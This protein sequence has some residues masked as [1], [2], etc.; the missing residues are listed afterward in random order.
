MA[1]A[2]EAMAWVDAM[3]EAEPERVDTTSSTASVEKKAPG[4][5][6]KK[7]AKKGEV[8]SSLSRA[9]MPTPLQTPDRLFDR[10][11]RKVSGRRLRGCL[12]VI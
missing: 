11:L 5:R 8:A 6:K 7:A 4:A 12:S 9:L 3:G 2:A 10:L 1:R